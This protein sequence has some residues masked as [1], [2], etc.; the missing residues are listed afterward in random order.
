L[1]AAAPKSGALSIRVPSRSNSTASI[2]EN[3]YVQS[4]KKR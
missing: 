3:M 2:L 4:R 1:S